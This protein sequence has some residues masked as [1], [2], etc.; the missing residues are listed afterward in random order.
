MNS[1]STWS[2]NDPVN[3]P[4][5]IRKRAVMKTQWVTKRTILRRAKATPIPSIQAAS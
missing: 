2:V 3:D 1:D 5:R 4:G